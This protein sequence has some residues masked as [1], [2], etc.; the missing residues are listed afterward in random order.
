MGSSPG[1][2]SPGSQGTTGIRTES[3]GGSS[4][5]D[6]PTGRDELGFGPYAEALAAFLTHKDTKPPLTISVEGGWGSGKSSFM[7]LL[8]KAIISAHEK[9]RLSTQDCLV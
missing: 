4:I 9:E 5:S 6:Q 2:S 3:V 1:S 8:R 7:L